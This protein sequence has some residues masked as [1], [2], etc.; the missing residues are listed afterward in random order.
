VAG[1]VTDNTLTPWFDAL[2]IKAASELELLRKDSVRSAQ[3]MQ[4][5]MARVMDYTDKQRVP[6]GKRIQSATRRGRSQWRGR[7][8]VRETETT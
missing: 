6:G 8:A 3:L 7:H 2:E 4:L 5:A 1:G